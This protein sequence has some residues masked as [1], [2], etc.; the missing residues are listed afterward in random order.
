M[1]T[2]P[3]LERLAALV[4]AQ[5][6]AVTE[7]LAGGTLAEWLYQHWYLGAGE[8]AEPAALPPWD[9][10][11]AVLCDIVDS[12]SPWSDGW[13]VVATDVEGNCHAGKGE[14]RRWAERGRYAGSD[15]AGLPPMP[16]DRISMP[17]YL[18]WRDTATGQWAAQSAE[19]PEGPIVRV[20]V[21]VGPDAIGH[22]VHRIVEWLVDE[23]VRFRMKCPG[24]ASAFARVDA[25]VLYFAESDWPGLEPGVLGWAEEIE[26]LVRPGHPA[27][28]LPLAPG[29]GFAQD[30]GD[31]RSFGQHRCA[32][33]ADALAALPERSGDLAEA[34]A[35]AI[36]AAGIELS[37]PW[38]CHA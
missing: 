22:A 27:L 10:L 32:L 25:L 35:Q 13:I 11:D 29:L 20:Y 6:A 19:P 31:G 4:A 37:A 16:G 14:Q 38:K 3:D 12:L 9:E 17:D 21:N 33:L 7:A 26:Q 24:S 1:T 8:P 18:S 28:T 2:H 34:L 23:D 30:P 5:P 36:E 15:R